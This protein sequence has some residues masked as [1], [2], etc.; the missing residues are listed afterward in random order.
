MPN[1]VGVLGMGLIYGKWLEGEREREVQHKLRP[2]GGAGVLLLL[3]VVLQVL[4]AVHEGL[5][6]GGLFHEGLFHELWVPT[7]PASQV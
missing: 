7:C 4:Q 5:F 6:H 3:L 1:W 2:K